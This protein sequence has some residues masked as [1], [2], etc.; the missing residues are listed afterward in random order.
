MKELKFKESDRIL[1]LAPHPDDESI[2]CGGILLKY[3][4]QCDVVVLTDGRHG[5]PPGQNNEEVIAIRNAEM[6]K[7]MSYVGV[8]NFQFL[9]IEDGKLSENFATFA[10]IDTDSYN[11][12]V[13]PHKNDNHSD[14]SCVYEYLQRLQPRARIIAYEVWSAIA[15]P[16]HYIDLTDVVEEKKRLI[17]FHK[18][19][20]EQVDYVSKT[21]GLN[22]YRG[23]L[24]Y[25][26]IQYAEAYEEMY[27]TKM[28]L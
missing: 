22:C 10:K 18:S 23:M 26:A 20:I 14:H 25:P 27:L 6:A 1:V 3:A 5:G 28:A 7:A 12:I 16:T 8:N 24:V 11:V 17:G 13:C 15:S 9:G 19:Q 4:S 2:G 21:I